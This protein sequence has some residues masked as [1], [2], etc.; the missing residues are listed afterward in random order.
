MGRPTPYH[1]TQIGWLFL[2][3]MILTLL[4]VGWRESSQLIDQQEISTGLIIMSIIIFIICL[5]FYQLDTSITYRKIKLRYG[6]GLI[7]INPNIDELIS[8]EI[9]RIPWW[10]GL[11]IKITSKGWMYNIQGRDVVMLKYQKGASKESIM[12]GTAQPEELKKSLMENFELKENP[13]V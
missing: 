7:K 13:V 5:L 12:I 1:E 2:S 6:I 10:Y 9:T 11:G 4:F 3:L 8:V